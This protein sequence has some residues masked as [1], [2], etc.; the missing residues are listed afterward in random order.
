MVVVV[1]DG[2]I[3][4]YIYYKAYFEKVIISKMLQEIKCLFT[5]KCETCWQNKFK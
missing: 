4:I 5:L 2:Y 1:T 3:Y